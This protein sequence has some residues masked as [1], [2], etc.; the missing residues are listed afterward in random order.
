MPGSQ[1]VSKAREMSRKAAGMGFLA[2]VAREAA[3][4]RRNSWSRV[5]YSGRKPAWNLENRLPVARTRRLR[6]RRWNALPTTEVREMPRYEP[7]LLLSQPFFRIGMMF[8]FLQSEGSTPWSQEKLKM[9]HRI[10]MPDGG[11]CRRKRGSKSSGPL[12]EILAVRQASA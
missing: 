1:L 9:H 8:A 7:S 2:D 11:W 10:S 12:A 5:E 6:I 3:S 4:C